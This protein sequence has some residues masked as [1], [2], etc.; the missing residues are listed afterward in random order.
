M[1]YC[2]QQFCSGLYTHLD[3][4]IPPTIRM[5]WLLGLKTIFKMPFVCVFVIYIFIVI[6]QLFSSFH[7]GMSALDDRVSHLKQDVTLY[8]RQH[9]SKRGD[10]E[11]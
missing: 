9:D 7:E 10:D 11:V 1:A 3:F 6:F 2:Y 4:H 8:R 5:T